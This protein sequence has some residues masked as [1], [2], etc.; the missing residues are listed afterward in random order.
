MSTGDVIRCLTV[1]RDS[2]QVICGSKQ[3]F[4]GV[5]DLMSATCVRE[6]KASFE[7]ES[8]CVSG[9]GNIVVMRFAKE[10]I[11]WD[12]TKHTSR[13]FSIGQ[14]FTGDVHLIKNDKNIVCGYSLRGVSGDLDG[15]KIL[16][17]EDGAVIGDVELYDKV[18]SI[19]VG[20]RNY[21]NDIK[22]SNPCRVSFFAWQLPKG[23]VRALTVHFFS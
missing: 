1:T 23:Q 5:Y 4:V 14:S 13:S 9:T 6:T 10:L 22:Q 2:K 15:L 7:V 19:R 11:V 18:D 3:G 21:T 8:V 12:L 20:K 17:I 16:S